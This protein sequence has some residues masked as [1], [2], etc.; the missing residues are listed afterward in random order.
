M[1]PNKP[2]P[3]LPILIGLMQLVDVT[4]VIPA[5]AGIYTA[6]T[7]EDWHKQQHSGFPLSRE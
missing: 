5:K 1:N 4:P 6:L 3:I 2:R 7:T